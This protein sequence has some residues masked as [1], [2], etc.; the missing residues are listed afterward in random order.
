MAKKL[1]FRLTRSDFRWTYHHGS[2]AG[3]QKRNKTQNA[4][5][6]HHDASG[7]MG[8]AQESRSVHDN[9][10]R[11]FER[12]ANSR[13]FRAWHRT[14]VA[15]RTGALVRVE[16]WL[17]REFADDTKFTVEVFRSGRWQPWTETP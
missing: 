9:E 4:V 1:L 8:Q 11:A 7:A 16:E 3:G 5:R 15:R 17:D 14:E 10:R 6:C 13:E 12:M 2:G